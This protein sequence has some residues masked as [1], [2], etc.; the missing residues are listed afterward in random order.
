MSIILHYNGGCSDCARKASRTAKLD[1]FKRVR[2]SIEDSPIGEVAKGEIVVVEDSSGQVHTGI[3]AT[4]SICMNVPAYLLY[5]L[6]LYVP[7]IRNLFA[8][9]QRGCDG[10]ACAVSVDQE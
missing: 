2:V 6:V 1:W 7:M 4:R 3:Y 10:D 8:K 9:G 5:G